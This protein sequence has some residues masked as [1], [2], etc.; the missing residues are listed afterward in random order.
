MEGFNYSNI[1]AQNETLETEFKNSLEQITEVAITPENI[2]SFAKDSL[3]NLITLNDSVVEAYMAQTPT[4]ATGKDLED[5][6]F[7]HFNIPSIEETIE[8]V[9]EIQDELQNIDT[10]I[11]SHFP[12]LDQDIMPPDQQEIPVSGDKPMQRESIER[13]KLKTI[14]F[15][16]QQNNIDLDELD[17]SQGTVSKEQWRELPY[18]NITIPAL[19][20]SVYVSNEYDNATFIFD[21]DRVIEEG[22]NPQDLSDLTKEEKN[23]YIKEFPGM[24][25]RR[26]HSKNY[27]ANVEHDLFN[28]IEVRETKATS[29]PETD[30]LPTESPAPEPA[31]EPETEYKPLAKSRERKTFLPFDDFVTEVKALY[32]GEGG[33]K[34]WYQEEK[35][36]P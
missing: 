27:A 4:T 7:S 14:L 18:Y 33:V 24:G 26:I 13:P 1:E 10:Y 29:E 12:L 2:D 17:T 16:L 36:S 8:H 11:Q 20:R 34:T 28:E 30:R 32:P 9:S 21:T 22:F 5:L 6:A 25:I 19:A 35:K 15:I 23:E 3:D 31:S